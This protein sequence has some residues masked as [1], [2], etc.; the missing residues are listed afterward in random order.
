ML[1]G[2]AAALWF[3]ILRQPKAVASFADVSLLP[4]EERS[5]AKATK[6]GKR[7]RS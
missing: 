5:A 4:R 6:S 3:Y 7:G 2:C 1:L